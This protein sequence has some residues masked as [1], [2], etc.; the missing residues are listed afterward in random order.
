MKKVVRGQADPS[1][2]IAVFPE[3]DADRKSRFEPEADLSG[4]MGSGIGMYDLTTDETSTNIYISSI[5][6]KVRRA[7]TLYFL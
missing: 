6:P 4:S 1:I 5:N 2:G 3:T 7:L